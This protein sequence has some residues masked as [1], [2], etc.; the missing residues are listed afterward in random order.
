LAA[1]LTR[2]HLPQLQSG[3]SRRHQESTLAETL[4]GVGRTTCAFKR[5]G[6]VDLN[7]ALI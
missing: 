6:G 4:P 3:G 2:A 1:A 5:P 7:V